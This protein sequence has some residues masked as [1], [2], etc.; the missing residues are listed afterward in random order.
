MPELTFRGFHLLLQGLNLATARVGK[1][2]DFLQEHWWCSKVVLRAWGSLEIHSNFC[3]FKLTKVFHFR[4]TKKYFGNTLEKK[5]LQ[6]GRKRSGVGLMRSF[7]GW[8]QITESKTI[9]RVCSSYNFSCLFFF[10]KIHSKFQYVQRTQKL[11]Q[12]TK[13]VVLTLRN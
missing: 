6:W 13:G 12:I 11:A 9:W 10:K 7:K 2:S 1:Q 8:S 3:H 5:E 4:N